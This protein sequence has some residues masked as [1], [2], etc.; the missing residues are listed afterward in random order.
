MRADSTEIANLRRSMRQWLATLN[1]GADR[2]QDILLASY[3][4]LANAV[5][6][7]YDA[8][9]E[10]ATVDLEA[11]YRPEDRELKVTVTDHGRWQD[12]IDDAAHRSRGHGLTLI[13]NLATEAVVSPGTEGTLIAMRWLD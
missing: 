6:H 4:A 2:V 8:S 1:L 9:D 13:R 12:A 11:T 7:A 10:S 5:E 3:E